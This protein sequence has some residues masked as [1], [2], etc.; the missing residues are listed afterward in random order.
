MLVGLKDH[1]LGWLT[2][3]AEISFMA[4]IRESRENSRTKRD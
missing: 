3:W 1:W 4:M 2:S